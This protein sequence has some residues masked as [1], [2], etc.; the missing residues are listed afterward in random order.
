MEDDKCSA[1]RSG[2]G[3]QIRIANFCHWRSY[4]LYATSRKGIHFNFFYQNVG[5]A[6][7]FFNYYF[8]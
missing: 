5:K 2:T 8:Y 1:T 4:L 3:I 6:L 7:T